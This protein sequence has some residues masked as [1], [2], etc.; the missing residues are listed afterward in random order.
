MA[1]WL[2]KR[3][4]LEF[5]S[6]SNFYENRENTTQQKKCSVMLCNWHAGTV[7]QTHY[8]C[9]VNHFLLPAHAILISND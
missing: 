6:F 8:K 5:L 7:A 1:A 9:Y 4:D 3:M 2:N